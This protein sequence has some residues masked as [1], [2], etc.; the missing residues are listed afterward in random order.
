MSTYWAILSAFDAIWQFMVQ[1]TT[2]G[3]EKEI[4]GE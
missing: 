4:V 3:I 1:I 2:K